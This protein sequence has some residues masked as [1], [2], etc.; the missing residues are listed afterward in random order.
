[1]A[2]A[3]LPIQ[4]PIIHRKDAKNAKKSFIEKN[5]QEILEILRFNL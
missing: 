1:M 4:K 5:N 3:R 2:L